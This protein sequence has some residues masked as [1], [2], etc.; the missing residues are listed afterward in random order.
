L[1]N[2]DTI[3]ESRLRISLDLVQ[4]P[5]VL[6]RIAATA[7]TPMGRSRIVHAQYIRELQPLYE[8]H[9]AMREILRLLSGS[10]SQNLSLKGAVEIQDETKRAAKGALLAPD[11]LLSI[12][13][14]LNSA[15]AAKGWTDAEQNPIVYHR[16]QQMPSLAALAQTIFRVVDY[17]GSIRDNASPAL[18]HIRREIHQSESEIDRLLDGILHSSHWAEYI[19]DA[20]VAIRFGRRVIPVKATFRNQVPGIVHDRSSSGQT[21]FVEPMPVVQ[22]QNQLTELHKEE[23]DEIRRLLAELSHTVGGYV[24]ECRIIEETVGWL[25]EMLGAAR[26]GLQTQS[27]LP[28]IGGNDL[29]LLDARHPL[30]EDPVPLDLS[31]EA[32]QHILIITGPNTGGKTVALRTT[33]LIVSLALTGMMVPCREGTAIPLFDRIWVDIGDEQSIEQNLS[34]FSSHMARLIPM[35]EFADAGTL[36]LVDEIGAGTD[37][38]EGSALAESMIYQLRERGAYAVVTTHYGRLKLLGFRLPDVENAQVAFDR[39]TLTPTYH[40]IMGQPGSSH[41]LYIAQRLGMPQSVVDRARALMDEEGTT[42]ADVIEQANHLQMELRQAKQQVSDQQQNLRQKIQDLDIERR[43][44]LEH[45]EREKTHTRDQWH[46]QMEDLH[47]EM[48]EAIENVRTHQGPEQGRAVEALRDIW[49]RRGILPKELEPP[50]HHP[51]QLIHQ[52]DY[53]H[54]RDF[55]GLGHVLDISGKTALVEVGALRVK[56]SLDDLE[57]AQSPARAPEGRTRGALMAVKAQQISI[58]CDVRGLTVDE[59]TEVVDKYLDDAVLAGAFQV[60]IIHGKGTGALRKATLQMLKNDSR[61]SHYR[62]GERGEG[63]DGVTVVSLGPDLE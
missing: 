55:E 30:I 38:D 5:E 44:W 36:C 54:V 12:G 35:M 40:L 1:N 43:R 61:V 6:R 45:S 52:G 41:A 3:A 34:T 29:R 16:L 49:R 9:D 59:M 63:G 60:R 10:D 47:E 14:T 46:K 15:D 31:L 19:Q 4:F 21:V 11:K 39:E 18:S 53:V 8:R 2:G 23:E 28:A 32:T 25:D 51:T 24:S 13:V 7:D 26:Y 57:R 58:E 42:L 37:P 50:Q 33:G 48:M 56:L 22:K 17:D 62:L 27:I 20:V